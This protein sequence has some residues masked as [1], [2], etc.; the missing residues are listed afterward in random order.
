MSSSQRFH[1]KSDKHYHVFKTLQIILADQTTVHNVWGFATAIFC[2]NKVRPNCFYSSMKMF[3]VRRWPQE[4]RCKMLKA[5]APKCHPSHKLK[6][7]G[8]IPTLS[9]TH[10][11]LLSVFSFKNFVTNDFQITKKKSSSSKMMGQI[12]SDTTCLRL[13]ELYKSR[14]LIHIFSISM[15]KFPRLKGKVNIR[16]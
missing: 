6:P 3:P 14:E 8:S 12:K 2:L 16:T 5:A 1:W 4:G 10:L 9:K 7:R 11:K 15:L 13:W